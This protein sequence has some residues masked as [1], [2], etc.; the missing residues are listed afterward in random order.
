MDAQKVRDADFYSNSRVSVDSSKS[1]ANVV[2][3]SRVGLVA[4]RIAN[5]WREGRKEGRKRK[6]KRKRMRGGEA[7]RGRWRV[8]SDRATG[9]TAG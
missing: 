8:S 7:S 1:S 2:R 3:L 6:R 4:V 9:G 5:K